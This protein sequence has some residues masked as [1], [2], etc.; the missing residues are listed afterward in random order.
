MNALVKGE[1]MNPKQRNWLVLHLL[2]PE[3]LKRSAMKKKPRAERSGSEECFL[4]APEI[5]V[6]T[7]KDDSIGEFEAGNLLDVYKRQPRK[8][9]PIILSRSRLCFRTSSKEASRACES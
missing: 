7:V 1:Q 3:R 2:H 5:P 9:N 6:L 8:E 4:I